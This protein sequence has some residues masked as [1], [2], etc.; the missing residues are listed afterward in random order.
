MVSLGGG[1]HRPQELLVGYPGARRPPSQWL[2]GCAQAI[3]LQWIRFMVE[4]GIQ[5]EGKL[6]FPGWGITGRGEA[7]VFIKEIL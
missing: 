1:F 7:A 2:P 3:S 5:N 6:G 4:I